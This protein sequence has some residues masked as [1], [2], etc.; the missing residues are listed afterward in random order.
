MDRN[1][2]TETGVMV[3]NDVVITALD[4]CVKKGLLSQNEELSSFRRT[5]MVASAIGELRSLL[6]PKVMEPI[7]NLQNTALGFKTDQIQAGYQIDVVRDCLIEACLKGVYPVGNEFN[8]IAR[9]CYIT[10]E[11]FA[12]KL[13]DIRGLSYTIT[14]DVPHLNA[15]STGAI[16]QMTIDWE[17]NSKV[18]TK[19]LKFAIRVNKMMGADA[20]IG[21]ATRK[22][23]AWL[24][25][26]VTGQE[27]GDGDV[28]D[29]PLGVIDV[30][31]NKK[32]VSRF[33]KEPEQKPETE[34]EIVHEAD[35]SESPEVEPGADLLDDAAKDAAKPA[36]KEV[37]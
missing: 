27:I 31:A 21:K 26:T 5:L 37:K 14:A 11:G 32:T 6:T 24:Y 13:R 22:A 36:E 17:F 23:R 10:K 8:I 15:E 9:Q 19:V 18:Q 29:S 3:V 33:E 2:K 35:I 7:M 25:T 34:G 30:K 28:V 20:I 12:H 16:I 1:M 4:E